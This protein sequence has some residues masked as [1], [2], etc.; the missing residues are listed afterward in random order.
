MKTSSMGVELCYCVANSITAECVWRYQM[1]L[2]SF[3]DLCSWRYFINILSTD[4]I[5]QV[6]LSVRDV[7]SLLK[8]RS[9]V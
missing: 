9:F 6:S 2:E 3:L 1:L 8:E 4:P 7:I 5:C